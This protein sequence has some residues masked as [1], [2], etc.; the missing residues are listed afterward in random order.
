[1]GHSRVVFG[2]C[3]FWQWR[4]M[5]MNYSELNTLTAQY[6]GPL[7][8]LGW[9]WAI[10]GF[11][12]RLVPFYVSSVL[13][14]VVVLFRK[15]SLSKLSTSILRGGFLV[16]FCIWHG[17]SSNLEHILVFSLKDRHCLHIS[18]RWLTEASWIKVFTLNISH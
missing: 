18:I 1:M 15:F 2:N 17:A 4:D 6:R 8:F 16:V 13:L 14:I 3:N 5:G 10:Y 12:M 9:Y 7:V 11:G